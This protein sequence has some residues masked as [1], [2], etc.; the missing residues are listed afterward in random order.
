MI[1]PKPRLQKVTRGPGLGKE[2]QFRLS[3]PQRPP[4]LN[5]FRPGWL[6]MPV[7]DVCGLLLSV[8]KSAIAKRLLSS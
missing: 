5:L 8:I 2:S 6:R 7:R 4:S 3:R 1:A